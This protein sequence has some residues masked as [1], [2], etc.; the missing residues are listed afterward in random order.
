MS[1]ASVFISCGQYTDVEKRLGRQIVELVKKVTGLEAYFAEE[2]QDLNGLD[3]NILAALREC[4]AFITVMHPRGKIVRPDGSEHVRASVWIEQEIAIATYIQRAEKRKLPVVAFI[5]KSVGHEGIRNLLHLNPTYFTD[6]SEVLA[7]LRDRLLEWKGLAATGRRV[8]LRSVNP[9]YQDGH[10]IRELEVILVND[11]NQ[12]I[13]KLNAIVR[14]PAGI[15][16]HWSAAYPTEVKSDD[17]RYRCFRFDEQQSGPIPPHDNRRLISFQY[18]TAC[19][20]PGAG[21]LAALVAE[22]TAD[23]KL[24][25]DD[26]EYSAQ[27]SIIELSRDAESAGDI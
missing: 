14:V 9:T 22:A 23:A 8:Q 25:V 26:R 15:L 12:L 24:W 7:G 1:K 27:K 21:G 16:K 10:A 5:H 11:T 20:L 6:E 13:T 18:C 17:P 4:A 3:S 2:V 19:A